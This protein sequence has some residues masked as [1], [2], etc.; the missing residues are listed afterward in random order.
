MSRAPF[1]AMLLALALASAA[2]AQDTTLDRIQNLT[3]TGRFTE[4]RNTLAQWESQFADPASPA[5]SADR[6]RAMYLRGTLTSDVKEAVETYRRLVLSY[7]SSTVAPL[8]LLRLGQSLLESGDARR[9]VTYLERLRNDYPGSSARET[10]WVWLARAQLAAGAQPAACKSVRDGLAASRDDNLR[11]LLE[12]E[13]D[14]AC[15]GTTGKPAAQPAPREPQPPNPPPRN[16]SAVAGA[17]YA[18]QIAAFRERSSAQTALAEARAKGFEA[19]I[20]TTD[21]TGLQRVRIGFFRTM[22]E[23]SEAARRVREAG[24]TTLIVSDI[25][26]ERTP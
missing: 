3:A 17:Q 10:G 13:Q 19:R 12:L 24:F 22:T 26:T 15:P 18:V 9:A 5:S 14:R 20:V 16:G 1:V 25:A 2:S 23:A 11:L 6:A 4:A 21:G 7:P 8:A